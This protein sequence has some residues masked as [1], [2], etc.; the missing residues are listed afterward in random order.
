MKVP[1]MVDVEGVLARVPRIIGQSRV[2]RRWYKNQY[3]HRMMEDGSSPVVLSAILP[4]SVV[5]K[6]RQAA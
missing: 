3:P 6:L 2:A 4:S 5:V 1:L